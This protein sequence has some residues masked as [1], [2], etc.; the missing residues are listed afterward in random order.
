[1]GGVAFIDTDNDVAFIDT[2]NDFVVVSAD[3]GPFSFSNGNSD[4]ASSWAVAWTTKSRLNSVLV[5]KG[6]TMTSA[7]I[8]RI[9]LPETNPSCS[10]DQDFATV[11]ARLNYHFNKRLLISPFR[12]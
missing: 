7:P 2:D 11:R 1:M 9:S 4:R 6:F 12:A 8:A 5:W 3:E 10:K